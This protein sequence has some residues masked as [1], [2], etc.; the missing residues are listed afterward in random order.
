MTINEMI[1]TLIGWGLIVLGWFCLMSHPPTST[2]VNG[3][4]NV[5]FDVSASGA[6]VF[7]GLGAVALPRGKG[8]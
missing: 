3:K 4:V 1:K 2:E 6:L 5:D 7:M 8:N